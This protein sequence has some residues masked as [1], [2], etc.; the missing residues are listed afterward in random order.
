MFIT[1]IISGRITDFMTPTIS[2]AISSVTAGIPSFDLTTAIVFFDLLIRVVLSIM[3]TVFLGLGPI[4]AGFTYV[5]RNIARE[6][7]AFILSDLIHNTKGNF[8]QALIVLIIDIVIFILLTMSFMIYSSLGGVFTYMRYVV[9]FFALIYL[10]MHLYIYQLMV[11]FRLSLWNL[12]KNAF[13]L[14]FANAPKNFL[15]LLISAIIHIF[16]PY[17]AIVNS[18]SVL[19]FPIFFVL[20]AVMLV[21]VSGFISTY[22]AY[23]SVEPLITT[24]EN[25]IDKELEI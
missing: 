9:G 14:A 8:F 10:M 1:G 7:H 21:A 15:L 4:S 6:D 12:Y 19:G 25:S 17:L 5:L 24:E 3:F 23:S 22:F 20:E 2:Q 16:V 11:T 13:I 18:T